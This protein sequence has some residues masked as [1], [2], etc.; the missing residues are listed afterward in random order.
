M[1]INYAFRLVWDPLWILMNLKSTYTEILPEQF[2]ILCDNIKLRQLSSPNSRSLHLN[3]WDLNIYQ[4]DSKI[5]DIGKSCMIKEVLSTTHSQP[6]QQLGIYKLSVFSIRYFGHLILG[7]NCL[8]Y[9]PG[10]EGNLSC[11]KF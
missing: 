8:N 3:T 11:H 6:Y 9:G 1:S 4:V 10:K 2:N 5:K 7:K